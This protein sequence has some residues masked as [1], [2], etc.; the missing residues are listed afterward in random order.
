MIDD[1]WLV[2]KSMAR[3]SKGKVADVARRV[4]PSDLAWNEATFL[5]AVE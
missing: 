1:I 4:N 2:G 5:C 3:Y